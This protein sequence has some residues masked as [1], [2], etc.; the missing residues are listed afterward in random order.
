MSDHLEVEL[1]AV[2]RC[3]SSC[4]DAALVFSSNSEHSSLLSHLSSS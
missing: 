1:Q 3:L 2:V 4:W